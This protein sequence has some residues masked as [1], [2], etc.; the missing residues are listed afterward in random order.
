MRPFCDGE[1]ITEYLSAI[2]NIAFH[3]KNNIGFEITVS[4]FNI[5]RRIENLSSNIT[6]KLK[7]KAS[8]L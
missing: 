6:E 5:G 3:D 7:E 4:H 2:T 1:M 8:N